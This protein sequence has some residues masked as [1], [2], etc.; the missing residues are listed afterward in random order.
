[1]VTAQTITTPVVSSINSKNSCSTFH[2]YI[3]LIAI[4]LLSLQLKLWIVAMFCLIYR[5]RPYRCFQLTVVQ[6][7]QLENSIRIL[8]PP[9]QFCLIIHLCNNS[10]FPLVNINYIFHFFFQTVLKF[11]HPNSLL[12][13]QL[14]F[15]RQTFYQI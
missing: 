13:N 2:N 3:I 8:E 4:V 6:T 5:H 15:L 14:N 7:H 10:H 9:I 11:N 1:M 12:V